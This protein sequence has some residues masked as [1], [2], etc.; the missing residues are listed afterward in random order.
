MGRLTLVCLYAAFAVA[1]GLSEASERELERR[2]HIQRVLAEEEADQ[3]G[4]ARPL[5]PARSDRVA[6]CSSRRRTMHADQQP[7]A[8]AAADR[9]MI[10]APRFTAHHGRAGSKVSAAGEGVFA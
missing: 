9:S 4:R 3:N 2:M 7:D 1:A 6:A 5:H 10:R 8:L